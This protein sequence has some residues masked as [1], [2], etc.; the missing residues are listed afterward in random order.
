MRFKVQSC[1]Y[2]YKKIFFFFSEI[3]FYRP[4]SFPPENPDVIINNQAN[5]S[6]PAVTTG[7]VAPIASIPQYSSR[8]AI[9][10]VGR[11]NPQRNNSNSNHVWHVTESYAAPYQIPQSLSQRSRAGV[12]RAVT[13]RPANVATTSYQGSTYASFP[14]PHDNQSTNDP[15]HHNNFYYAPNPSDGWL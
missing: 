4:M 3:L 14:L 13:P 12:A 5:T 10:A 8:E 15:T 9:P 2:I 11:D 1:D 6:T 7:P